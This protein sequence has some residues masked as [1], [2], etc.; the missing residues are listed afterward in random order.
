MKGEASTLRQ[1]QSFD[2]YHNFT[3]E[4]EGVGVTTV[5]E[6]GIMIFNE[7]ET[8]KKKSLTDHFTLQKTRCMRFL[9]SDERHK[10]QMKT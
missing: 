2:I 5:S 7:Y 6:D 9:N 3:D 4:Q 8:T 1:R 10:T